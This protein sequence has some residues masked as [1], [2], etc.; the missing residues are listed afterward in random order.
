MIWEENRRNK[1]ARDSVLRAGWRMVVQPILDLV[2]T[3]TCLRGEI[4]HQ[5]EAL[6]TV[7]GTSHGGFVG[8][9]MEREVL[10]HP[11]AFLV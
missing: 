5:S 2:L 3:L 4:G 11:Q 6:S 8:S 10:H 7:F 9:R 1:P